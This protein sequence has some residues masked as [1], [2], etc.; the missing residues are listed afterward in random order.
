[1]LLQKA[2]Y[3][4]GLIRRSFDY[5]NLDM[6]VKIFVTVVHPTLEYRTCVS[7]R[8]GIFAGTEWNRSY[9]C[10]L[11]YCIYQLVS[12]AFIVFMRYTSLPCASV[13]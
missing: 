4:L 11:P 1:M 7:H 2:N 3:L 8:W 9:S 6:L 10:G 5:L 12:I 13:Y